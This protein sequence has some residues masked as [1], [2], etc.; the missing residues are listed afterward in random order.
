MDVLVE[1]G[2]GVVDRIR[3]RSEAMAYIIDRL[4]LVSSRGFCFFLF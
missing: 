3:V 4:V 2:R 1:K